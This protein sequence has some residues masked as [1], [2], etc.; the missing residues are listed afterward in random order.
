MGGTG[1]V[2]AE[3]SRQIAG[4]RL[5]A[6]MVAASAYDAAFAVVNLLVPEWGARMLV[7]PLPAETVY[8]RF[9]SV[10]LVILALFYL[11]PAIHPGR[12][13]GN[14]VVAIVGRTAGAVFLLA[15]TFCF[16][17]PRGFALLGLGD[18]AF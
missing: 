14:V 1:E 12:Y 17:L 10:F 13:L 4:R 16:G 18:L 15:A 11:L 3:P 6:S 2:S 8:L 9:T 7:I 5:R